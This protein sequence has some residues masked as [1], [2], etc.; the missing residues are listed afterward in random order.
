VTGPHRGLSEQAT[1]AAINQ[2]LPD[3]ETAGDPSLS[4]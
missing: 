2:P 3:A 4:G 1:D